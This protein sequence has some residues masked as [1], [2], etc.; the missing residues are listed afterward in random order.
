VNRAQLHIAARSIL[1][2]ARKQTELA[3][4][5]DAFFDMHMMS[6]IILAALGEA[7]HAVYESTPRDD[8]FVVQPEGDHNEPTTS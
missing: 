8:S 2:S 3:K 1:G 6:A 4:P 7:L 5:G